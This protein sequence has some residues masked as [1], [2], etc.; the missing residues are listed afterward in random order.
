MPGGISA[1]SHLLLA[2]ACFGTRIP[3]IPWIRLL[4]SCSSDS[5]FLLVLEVLGAEELVH[6]VQEL[7]LKVL[8]AEE[9]VHQVQ[10]LTEIPETLLFCCE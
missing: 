5:R 6:Q 4:G 2:R 10:E 7:V 3:L 1:T 8:G 9:L